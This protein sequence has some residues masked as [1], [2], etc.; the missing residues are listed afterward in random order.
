MAPEIYKKKYGAEVDLWALGGIAYFMLCGTLP[1]YNINQ[2]DIQRY[3][4][5]VTQITLPQR[6]SSASKDFVSRLLTK[7]VSNRLSFAELPKHPFISSCIN[8]SIL[9]NPINNDEPPTIHNYTV[10]LAKCLEAFVPGSGKTGPGVLLWKNLITHLLREIKDMPG[11]PK[12]LTEDPTQ[13]C[14]FTQDGLANLESKV[15]FEDKLSFD[16]IEAFVYFKASPPLELKIAGTPKYEFLSTDIINSESVPQREKAETFLKLIHKIHDLYLY[17]MD[18]CSTALKG[19]EIMEKVSSSYVNGNIVPILNDLYRKV[20]AGSGKGFFSLVT[21]GRTDGTNLKMFNESNKTVF[22][23]VIQQYGILATFLDDMAARASSEADVI[24]MGK[25]LS[26]AFTQRN[27]TVSG[28]SIVFDRAIETFYE[29]WNALANHMSAFS[30]LHEM[31]C[32]IKALETTFGDK[33]QKMFN[34][35]NDLCKEFMERHPKWS[36][37]VHLA[38]KTEGQMG[39]QKKK[40]VF[41]ESEQTSVMV[42]KF[43]QE[44][45]KCIKMEEEIKRLNEKIE[46]LEAQLEMSISGQKRTKL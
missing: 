45:E 42:E 15:D 14:V 44:H 35:E 19:I 36:V 30:D 22:K 29:L 10:D 28:T 13:V 37:K 9:I 24:A 8:F 1:M 31:E 38:E 39:T 7:E 40:K 16:N 6:F 41:E 20:G 17:I 43:L 26:F 25:S 34:D 32:K 2:D 4:Q 18:L 12:C 11:V 27:V 33:P 23:M 5:G 21:P 3:V 46:S